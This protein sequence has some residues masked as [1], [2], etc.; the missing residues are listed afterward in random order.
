M[1]DLAVHNHSAK[2]L[3]QPVHQCVILPKCFWA[4]ISQNFTPYNTHHIIY[5]YIRT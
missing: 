5:R 4:A 3:S 2:V 1:E